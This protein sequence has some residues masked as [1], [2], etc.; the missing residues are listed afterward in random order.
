VLTRTYPC[1]T[2][3]FVARRNYIVYTRN[4]ISRAYMML[5]MI[6]LTA[7]ALRFAFGAV[8]VRALGEHLDTQGRRERV[9]RLV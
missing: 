4:M 5:A 6:V 2:E 9:M 3:C 1:D 8:F 7:G